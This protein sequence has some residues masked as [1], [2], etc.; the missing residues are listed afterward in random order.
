MK[1]TSDSF[2]SYWICL[3]VK[4]SPVMGQSHEIFINLTHKWAKWENCLWLGQRNFFKIAFFL[5]FTKIKEDSGL[6]T[7]LTFF[8]S[9]DF[10]I[11]VKTIWTVGLTLSRLTPRF[12]DSSGVYITL[13]RLTPRGSYPEQHLSISGLKFPGKKTP[14]CVTVQCTRYTRRKI[15]SHGNIPIGNLT[16]EVDYPREIT[17]P[18]LLTHPVGNCTLYILLYSGEIDLSG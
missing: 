8:V 7:C 10:K 11:S 1:V 12:S 2:L 5:D 14:R 16:W 6:K 9:V 13:I 3:L 15:V 4:E 18:N 17:G